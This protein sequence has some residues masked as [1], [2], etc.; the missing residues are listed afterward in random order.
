MDK[1]Q[2][3]PVEQVQM[4]PSQAQLVV[5]GLC[6]QDLEITVTAVMVQAI[7]LTQEVVVVA[8]FESYGQGQHA[9]SH[10]LT[11]GICNA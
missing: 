8:R 2:T 11:H 3:G 6:L 7:L 10:R 4:A 9:A 5:Q 1:V